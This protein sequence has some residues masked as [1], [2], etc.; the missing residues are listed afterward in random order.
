[1]SKAATFSSSFTPLSHQ[2]IS[3]K[4]SLFSTIPGTFQE[5]TRSKREK[6]DFFQSEAERV[7]PHYPEAFGLGERNS[8]DPEIAVKT[9]NRIRIPANGNITPTHNEPSVV[10]PESNI[11]RNE[12]WF[13]Y[14]SLQRKTKRTM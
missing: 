9:S 3:D 8:K 11:N 1:M 2:K 14:P 5:K 13:K 12:L 7:R 10:T 6:Q 4:E